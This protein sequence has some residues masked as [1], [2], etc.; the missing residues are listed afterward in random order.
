ML[1]ALWPLFIATQVVL[2]PEEFNGGGSRHT[3]QVKAEAQHVKHVELH[4]S[5]RQKQEI[6]GTLST[7]AAPH[8]VSIFANTGQH[9]GI[10]GRI[11]V[12]SLE[13]LSEFA[14]LPSLVTKAYSSP[15]ALASTHYRLNVATTQSQSISGAITTQAT[16]HEPDISTVKD[17]LTVA[18]IGN[19]ST[20]QSRH[21]VGKIISKQPVAEVELVSAHYQLNASTAQT[22]EISGKINTHRFV[23]ANNTLSVK[24]ATYQHQVISGRITTNDDE[25]ML[26][27][28]MALLE[29]DSDVG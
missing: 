28:L 17:S 23:D 14:K 12:S 13:S 1:L 7:V 19:I 21:I 22:Q 29:L 25:E 26:M 10:T 27:V 2:P 24:A 20:A 9:Q 16:G 4:V 11:N 3:K 15:D 18:A 8:N 5:T 6:K